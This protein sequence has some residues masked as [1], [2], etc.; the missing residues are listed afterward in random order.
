MNNKAG[1]TN[2][3]SSSSSSSASSIST[4]SS[5]LVATSS[6]STST[7]SSSNRDFENDLFD[8]CKDSGNCCFGTFCLPCQSGDNG[9]ALSESYWLCFLTACFAPYI[10]TFLTRRKLRKQYG[11]QGSDFEDVVASVCCGCCANIQI[12]NEL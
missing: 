6:S 1:E 9:E 2:K 11:I 12:A 8:C 7:M 3:Q 5:T 4:Q 10:S